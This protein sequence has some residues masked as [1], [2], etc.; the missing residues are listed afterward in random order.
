MINVELTAGGGGKSEA[1]LSKV[2]QRNK[3]LFGERVRLLGH[4]LYRAAN[5]FRHS[6]GSPG[7]GRGS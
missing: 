6:E 7:K 5:L 4:E 3:E 1:R 2:K